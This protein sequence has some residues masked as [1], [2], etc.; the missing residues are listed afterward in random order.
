MMHKCEGYKNDFYIKNRAL[1]EAKVYTN[2]MLFNSS[3]KYFLLNCFYWLVGDKTNEIMI[4]YAK[5]VQIILLKSC[6][7]NK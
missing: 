5:R 3:N 7:M 2:L 1:K 4:N 6:H